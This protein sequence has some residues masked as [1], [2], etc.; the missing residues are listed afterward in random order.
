VSSN[1]TENWDRG[2]SASVFSKSTDFEKAY[3]SNTYAWK[4]NDLS[5]SK[6]ILELIFSKNTDAMAFEK[7]G[8]VIYIWI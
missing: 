7:N 1:G 3:P 6:T 8:K 2:S 5:F 4:N